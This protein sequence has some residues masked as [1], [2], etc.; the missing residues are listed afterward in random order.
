MKV[1]VRIARTTSGRYLAW[2]PALPGCTV[3][4]HSRQE[5]KRKIGE[6]FRGYLDHLETALPRELTRIMHARDADRH[7]MSKACPNVRT[8]PRPN[9]TLVEV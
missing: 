3:V 8:A 5:A 1:C 6:A 9:R 4:A 7:G 2:C